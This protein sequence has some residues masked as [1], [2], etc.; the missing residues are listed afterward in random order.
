VPY[1]GEC[2][3]CEKENGFDTIIDVVDL[4]SVAIY[5]LTKARTPVAGLKRRWVMPSRDLD[6]ELKCKSTR[7]ELG[8]STEY[9]TKRPIF[10]AVFLYA[11]VSVVNVTI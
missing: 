7:R 2:D 10:T 11:H 4:N 8:G 1:F 5:V 3:V 6:T 9:L